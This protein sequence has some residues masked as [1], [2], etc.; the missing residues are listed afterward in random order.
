M[1]LVSLSVFTCAGNITSV[2]VYVLSG[3]CVSDSQDWNFFVMFAE[4]FKT[5]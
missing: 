5:C 2:S 1:K 4:S 3:S